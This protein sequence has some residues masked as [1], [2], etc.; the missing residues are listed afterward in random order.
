MGILRIVIDGPSENLK[1][2]LF[3]AGNVLDMILKLCQEPEV[4]HT[5]KNKTKVAKGYIAHLVVLGNLIDGCEHQIAR[6]FCVG[7]TKWEQFVDTFLRNANERNN[8]KIGEIIESKVS[9]P[10]R[11]FPRTFVPKRK[12][13]SE[14]ENIEEQIEEDICEIID[15]PTKDSPSKEDIEYLKKAVG[16]D[17]NP[18]DYDDEVDPESTIEFSKKKHENLFNNLGMNHF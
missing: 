12:A 10:L 4:E 1:L 9:T 7:N 8:T 11:E 18:L 3:K 13:S 17:D 16:E 15:I 6:T 5:S 14:D 2:T